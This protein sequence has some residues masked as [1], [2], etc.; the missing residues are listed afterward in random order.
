ML[1]KLTPI[2]L[3]ITLFAIMLFFALS[4]RDGQFEFN[5]EIIQL[6][7]LPEVITLLIGTLASVIATLAIHLLTKNKIADIGIVGMTGVNLFLL[8]IIYALVSMELFLKIKAYVLPLAYALGSLAILS[9]IFILTYKFR[10]SAEKI[11]LI[12][13]VFT[14]TISA[15]TQMILSSLPSFKQAY[16]TKFSVG[17]LAIGPNILLETSSLIAYGMLGIALILL[18]LF[19]KKIVIVYSDI[20][21]A[22]SI[23]INIKITRAILFIIIGLASAT[24]F[25]FFGA[26][27]FIGFIATNIVYLF[28]KRVG[29]MQ[30]LL[31]FLVGF[32]LMLGV[33]LLKH[34]LVSPNVPLGIITNVIAIPYLIF[35]LWKGD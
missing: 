11:I 12:G 30:F 5:W 18:G 20:E 34:T 21:K 16:L 23:G 27:A 4:F 19:A 33:Y 2:I 29:I 15:V 24:A 7:R 28:Y 3:L 35:V 9:S 17:F 14:L 10:E 31:A 26:I 25:I 22:S 13:I 6:I 32:I 8:T 1:K